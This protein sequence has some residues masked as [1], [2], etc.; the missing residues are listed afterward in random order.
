MQSLVGL[1]DIPHVQDRLVCVDGQQRVTTTALFVSALA[2]LLSSRVGMSEQRENF[3]A[4]V[5]EAEELLFNNLEEVRRLKGSSDISFYP[6]LRLLPSEL[7]R[8]PFLLATLGRRNGVKGI[9]SIS[10]ILMY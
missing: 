2:D 8:R 7:D 10:P 5:G 9:I 4:K 1:Q 3:S 6:Y